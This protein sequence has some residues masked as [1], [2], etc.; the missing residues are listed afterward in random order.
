MEYRKANRSDIDLFV[1]NRME[2]ATSIRNID[3]VP[4]FEKMTRE[5]IESHM[6]D[7]VVVFLA[8]EK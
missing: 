5:Y 2:F 7:E 4:T 6:D 8:M 1:E 3:D